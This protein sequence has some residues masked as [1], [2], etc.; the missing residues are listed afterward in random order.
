MLLSDLTQ[1][2]LLSH[3]GRCFDVRY[4]PNSDFLLSAS[5]DGTAILW[6]A[7][8]RKVHFLS[9]IPHLLN[10]MQT[11]HKL[12]S[13]NTGLICQL[14]QAHHKFKHNVESE[15]LRAAFLDTSSSLITTCG[16]DGRAIIWRSYYEDC[17][18]Q[19]DSKLDGESS[20]SLSIE[21]SKGLTDS[22]S[23]SKRGNITESNF[24]S[25]QQTGRR[26][27]R[28]EAILP[29]LKTAQIYACECLDINNSASCMLMTAADS[30]VYLWDVNT[31]ISGA[32]SSSNESTPSHVWTVDSN[33]STNVSPV[34]TPGSE[35]AVSYGGPR[36]PDNQ[37]FIFD[38]KVNPQDYNVI[39]LALSNGNIRQ[40]DV[41]N[42][43]FA[44][45]SKTV[46]SFTPSTSSRN[47]G[48]NSDVSTVSSISLSG[49][50]TSPAKRS[51][52]GNTH[53]T[54]VRDFFLFLIFICNY[55]YSV[56]SDYFFI[57]IL[58]VLSLSDCPIY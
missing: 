53:A 44:S 33:S 12:T 28:K 21:D 19:D 14:Q 40:I 54:S 58:A 37:V 43:V 31:C 42:P 11:Y 23:A 35:E 22:S 32:S 48:E 45:I 10:S 56:L 47:Y 50:T 39:G 29:H 6:D 52:V 27:I 3:T 34:N 26:R 25:S 51:R 15:V 18:I 24:K 30:S 4:S 57:F 20:K 7:K 8:T 2:K 46:T 17:E 1:Q 55:S 5:E 41:R 49:L 38:A 13:M 36:N 16:A 9:L